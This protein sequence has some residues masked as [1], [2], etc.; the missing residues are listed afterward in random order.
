[1]IERQ[2]SDCGAPITRKSKTGR[3]SPCALRGENN[4]N[5]SGENARTTSKRQRAQRAFS[6]VDKTCE[7]CGSAATVRHHRDE[8]PGNNAPENI[9]FLCTPCH[10]R[11]HGPRNRGNRTA[12]AYRRRV[13]GRFA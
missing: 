10:L 4:P 9:E 5:W 11:L 6:I 2:C 1:M 13:N 7:R 12:K 3:C 8:N